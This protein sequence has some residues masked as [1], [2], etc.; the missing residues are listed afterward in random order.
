MKKLAFQVNQW[1]VSIDNL[2]VV[3]QLDSAV[4]ELKKEFR[5]T[6]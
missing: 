3:Y 6:G 2:A 1:E 5:F 4:G